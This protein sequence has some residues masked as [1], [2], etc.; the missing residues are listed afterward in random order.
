MRVLYCAS[1]CAP[2]FG[3]GGLAEVAGALPDAL[4][5]LPGGA[6]DCRVFLPFYSSVKE[7]YTRKFKQIG[8][9]TVAVGWRRQ[10][11]ILWEYK[12]GS[13]IYY[14][15]SNAY[16]FSRPGSIYGHYDDA[17]RFACFSRGI[18]EALELLG[19]WTPEL[20]H[21]NDWH[22]ALVPVYRSFYPQHMGIRTVLT[23]H[24]LLFQGVYDPY[25]LGDVF[26]L[27]EGYLGC[28]KHREAL[29]LLRGGITCA[30]AV[31]AVSPNYAKEILTPGGG[32]G[33]DGVLRR[34]EGKL[35]GILNGID[36][37]LYN[38][39]DDPELASAYSAE[40]TAG[41]AECKAQL[42]TLFGLEADAAAPVIGM[43]TRLSAQKGLQ[44]LMDCMEGF[45]NNYRAQLVMLGSGDAEY[46]RYF[47]CLSR[48]FPG[49]V[50][51]EFA[52]NPVLAHKVYAGS[53][54][55]L[56]PS[57]FEPCGLGQMY[58]L[59][60]GAVPIVRETGGLK[61]TISDTNGIT[62]F[63]PSGY[64]LYRALERAMSLWGDKA[65]YAAQQKR[66]MEENH[67]WTTSA[68]AYAQMYKNLVS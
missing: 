28:M 7:E 21:C 56:M 67:G 12:R 58:A 52:Y 40:N 6:V 54:F 18:W 45:L 5:A 50:G 8:T 51:I 68:A 23:L 30:D 39:A 64:E 34:Y 25:I 42:Q 3:S 57:L 11:C 49:R 59:R 22:T 27:D 41:K 60:Y 19:D 38:P 62:F 61:D 32:E 47:S 29:N 1:E 53:D 36:N 37:A 55:F 65:G 14:F 33:L 4:N 17:E 31:N 15:L 13:V 63:D 26:G 16:Y 46:E 48:R 35:R 20:I 9:L 66:G 2:F 44:M 24:N 43:V 10:E